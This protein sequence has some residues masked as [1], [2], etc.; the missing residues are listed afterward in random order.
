MG[1]RGLAKGEN[2]RI[3][4]LE[5]KLSDLRMENADL[6]SLKRDRSNRVYPQTTKRPLHKGEVSIKA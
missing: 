6:L 5:S 2:S 4:R 3:L 1:S